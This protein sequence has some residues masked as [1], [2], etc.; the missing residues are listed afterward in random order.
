MK[1]AAPSLRAAALCLGSLALGPHAWSAGLMLP[2]D[3]WASW[4]VPAV[5]E[6][7]D[8]CC[9]SSWQDRNA[10]RRACRLDNRRD[11]YG[12]RGDATTEIVRVYARVTDG[13]VD[14]LRVLSAAC[15]IETAMPIREL[16]RVAVDDSVRWLI[17]LAKQTSSDAVTRQRVGD[18]V[19]AALAVHRGDR[20]RNALAAVARNDANDEN[21]KQALFWL[22]SLRGQEGAE[23]VILAA[24]REDA[25]EEVREQAVFAL[26]RLPDERATRALISTAE[27]QS[28]SR[29]QRK[30]AVF[31]LA[32]S[33]SAAAEKYLE[34]VLRRMN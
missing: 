26:S 9:W 20:A 2:H 13:K 4:E 31:W 21:R 27:D 10:S 6:T 28:L 19:L 30:Q 3:G 32:Q 7:P 34:K 8:W 25:D 18:D 12:A 33:E 17:D 22:A 14:R 23:G 11:G 15:P 1:R 5:D 29:E 24:M 16:G